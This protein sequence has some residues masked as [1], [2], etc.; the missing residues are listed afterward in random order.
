MQSN[1]VSVV[2]RMSSVHAILKRNMQNQVGYPEADRMKIIDDIFGKNGIIGK[3]DIDTF[4][5]RLN[6]LRTA[7]TEKDSQVGDKKFMP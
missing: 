7:I 6:N 5:Y 2:Q 3:I 4:D 1:D